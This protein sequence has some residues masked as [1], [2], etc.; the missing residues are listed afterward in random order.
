MRE[1]HGHKKI[2]TPFGVPFMGEEK[3]DEELMGK[4]KSSPRLSTASLDADNVRMAG[5][6]QFYTYSLQK[7][8]KP[9][10]KAW[11]CAVMAGA[12]AACKIWYDS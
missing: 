7:N 4:R 2:G 10:E 12:C 8:K 6:G 9:Q 5:D 11:I 1:A 3:P